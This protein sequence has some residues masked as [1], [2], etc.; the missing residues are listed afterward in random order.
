MVCHKKLCPHVGYGPHS[1][2]LSA[3]L[4]MCTRPT[5]DKVLLCCIMEERADKASC[6]PEVCDLRLVVARGEGAIFVSGIHTER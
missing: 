5:Q 1:P 4:V 6:L 2:G 3:A